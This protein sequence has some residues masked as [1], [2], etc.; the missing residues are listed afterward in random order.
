ML[1]QREKH[2]RNHVVVLRYQVVTH[3]H[4]LVVVGLEW[5]SSMQPKACRIRISKCKRQQK[6]ICNWQESHRGAWNV[7]VKQG[8]SKGATLYWQ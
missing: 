6:G 1:R 2:L 3:L 4:Y 5:G 8:N 7:S